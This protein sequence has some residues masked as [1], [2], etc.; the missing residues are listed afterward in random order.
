MRFRSF[1][2][3]G[4]P[5]EA[6]VQRHRQPPAVPGVVWMFSP[7]TWNSGSVVST[8]SWAR[9]R[10]CPRM[11]RRWSAARAREHHALGSPVEPEVEAGSGASSS[12]ATARTARASASNSGRRR[13][14]GG[15]CAASEAA[16]PGRRRPVRAGGGRS[17]CRR[18]AA[19]CSGAASSIG[20]GARRQFSGMK[21]V[22]G[23]HR[24][25]ASRPGRSRDQSPA[26]DR[27]PVPTPARRTDPAWR[28]ARARAAVDDHRPRS[29]RRLA[30]RA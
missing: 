20:R 11:R 21:T 9:I 19:A 4:C 1:S 3:E 14:L 23:A 7:P 8:R 10:A 29:Q 5:H 13:P 30:R 6:R 17:A 12:G 16:R 2:V 25:Q 22:P 15:R 18:A 27:S 26:G 28:P 24:E